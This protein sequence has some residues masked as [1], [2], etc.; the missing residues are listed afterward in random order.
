MACARRDFVRGRRR[1]G[2][3]PLCLWLWEAL[4]LVVNE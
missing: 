1:E 3:Q 2:P 4:P